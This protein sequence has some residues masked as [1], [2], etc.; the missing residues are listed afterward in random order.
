MPA[1]HSNHRDAPPQGADS[2]LSERELEEAEERSSV[3]AHV[4]HEAVRREG[5][6]ELRRPSTALAWSGLAA[7][8]S[9]GFS[10]IAEGLIRSRLPD[11]PWRPLVSKLGYSF[12]FV[13]VVLGRQ[14]LFTENTLT[15][16]LPL[17]ERPGREML[18]HVLRLWVIVLAMNLVGAVAI[19]W[20]LGNSSVFRPEVRHAFA[21][22]GHESANVTFGLAVL[23]GVFAGW[24]IAFM[25]WL[26]PFAESA[27]LAVI[28]GLTWL[29]GLGGFTHVIAG[30][31]EVLFLVTTGELPWHRC[32][33]GYILPTLIGNILGGVSLVAA[34]NHAQVVS[35]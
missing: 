13:L 20:V 19:A 9:M 10:L 30:S 6:A 33:F 7:G 3:R 28:V 21:E 24:L 15:P 14:Q 5:E 31:I 4:V 11:L 18:W 2:E 1:R 22:I 25:V 32:A 17:L 8:L 23:R 27:R 35:K 12:G 34:L 16:I 26:L 29:V